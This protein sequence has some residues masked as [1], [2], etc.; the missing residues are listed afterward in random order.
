MRINHGIEIEGCGR[1]E[2]FGGA[3]LKGVIVGGGEEGEGV[4]GV[5]GEMRDA[6]FMGSGG[7]VGFGCWVIG[8]AFQRIFSALEVPEMYGGGSAA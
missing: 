3:Y 6:E 4:K 7:F 5:K 1:S 2:G 8:A